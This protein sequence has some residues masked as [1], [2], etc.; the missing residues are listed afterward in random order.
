VTP[1]DPNPEETARIASI[2]CET[3]RNFTWD[4][5]FMRARKLGS[6]WHHPS[7]PTAFPFDAQT[8]PG[9]RGAAGSIIRGKR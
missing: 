7:C 9:R 4:R 1:R 6:R 2:T 8:R 5:S 3:C